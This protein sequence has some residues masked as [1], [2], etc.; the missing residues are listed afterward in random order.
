MCLNYVYEYEA[1][2]IGR[3]YDFAIVATMP[4]VPLLMEE[5]NGI[6]AISQGM[7]NVR[8]I[9]FIEVDGNF[10]H[11]DPNDSQWDKLTPTQ[12]HNMI[13]DNLKNEWCLKHKIPLLRIWESDIRKNPKLV[14]SMITEQIEKLNTL[15]RIKANMHRPHKNNR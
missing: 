14:M 3:F 11:P 5:K 6:E 8:P 10:W 2:E 1:K 13:V 7:N 15:D 9:L 4:D 12:K